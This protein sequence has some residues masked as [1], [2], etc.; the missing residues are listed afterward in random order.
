[1]GSQQKNLVYALWQE[2]PKL[3]YVFWT[4]KP[5]VLHPQKRWTKHMGWH[6]TSVPVICESVHLESESRHLKSE[7]RHL[8]SES[9]HL[10]SESRHLKSESRHLESE[11]RHVE[12][13]SRHLKSGFC[14]IG[15]HSFFLESKSEST[16]FESEFESSWSK[17]ISRSVIA[18]RNLESWFESKSTL[19]S[20][21]RI[22]ILG[23]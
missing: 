2:V 21:V 11:S 18:T 3:V 22:W 1:M 7:S 20:W 23:V 16:C 10:K 8:K 14:W 17:K 9:R 6:C 4:C 13:E 15:I 19:F 5:V 12:S